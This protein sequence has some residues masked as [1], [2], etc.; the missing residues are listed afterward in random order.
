MHQ[1]NYSRTEGVRTYLCSSCNAFFAIVTPLVASVD[2]TAFCPQCK[3][4]THIYGEGHITHR[5]N[6]EVPAPIDDNQPVQQEVIIHTGPKYEDK[7]PYVL[8]AQHVQEILDIGKEKAYELMESKGFP[9]LKVGR[10]K[11]V[12]RDKF[13]QWL[14]DPDGT[15]EQPLKDNNLIT[16]EEVSSILGCSKRVAYEIMDQEDFPLIKV[17]R[18]KKVEKEELHK[19]MKQRRL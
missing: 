6:I 17:G 7:F 14:R 19:W 8:N 2:I 3:E 4:E 12:L 15:N 1:H 18:L 11:K 9:V 5:Q 13:F 16:A 10:H